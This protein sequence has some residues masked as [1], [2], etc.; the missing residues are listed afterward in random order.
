MRGAA[1]G[2]LGERAAADYL[3]GRGYR[4]D[5]VNVRSRLGEIDIVA[6]KGD[7]TAF[8]EVK[9][10]DRA[11]IYSGRQA[12]TAAKQRRILAA[13]MG[14]LGDRSDAQP[15]FDVL[16]IVIDSARST[17]AALHILSIDH[18]ENAF[19]AEGHHAFF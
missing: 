9:T 10:R 16:E 15:R 13:A 5:A 18:L 14:Y 7:I 11:A 8:V 12:V 4:I 17:A 3:R 1:H 19:S 6:T 2:A